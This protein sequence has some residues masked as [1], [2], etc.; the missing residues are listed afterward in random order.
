M[1]ASTLFILGATVASIIWA[2]WLNSLISELAQKLF[3]M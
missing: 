2:Y 3:M 1:R